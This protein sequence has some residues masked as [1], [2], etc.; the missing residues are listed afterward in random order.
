MSATAPVT[1]LNIAGLDLTELGPDCYS[2]HVENGEALFVNSNAARLFEVD[3]ESLTGKGFLSVVHVQ[4]RVAVARAID[5]CLNR[6][7]GTKAQFRTAGTGASRALWCELRCKR[8]EIDGRQQVLAVCRDIS[9]RRKL[10][11]ELQQARENAESTTIA[12]SRFLANMSHELR[13]PLNAI[14]GFSE[15]L[16]SDVMQKMPPE[17]SK[18]YVSLIHGSASHLLNVLNDI[19]DMSKIEAGKYEIFTEPFNIATTLKSC[20]SM[21]RGQADKRGVEI[22]LRVQEGLPEVT[23]DER[24]IKQVMINLLSNAVKFSEDGSHIEVDVRRTGMNIRISVTDHGIGISP[25]HIKSLG[26]P[27]YQ[28]DSKYDHKYEGTGLGLSVVCG[29]VELHKGKVR[30]ESVKGE[31]TTVTVTLPI[32]QKEP[33]PVPASERLEIVNLAQH[34]NSVLGAEDGDARKAI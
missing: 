23:A 20:C 24:A 32:A 10:E 34:R 13:T 11:Q 2:L 18:E 15:L 30:F 14:L 5:D 25:E 6:G 28:A 17:R 12:K 8:V 1:N 16:Q 3:P 7:T 31:G 9:E 22:S 21:M 19:L 26:L 33:K 4:D 27:F 29:L